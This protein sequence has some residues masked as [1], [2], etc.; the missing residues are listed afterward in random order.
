[1]LR[2]PRPG[3]SQNQTSDSSRVVVSTDGPPGQFSALAVRNRINNAFSEKGI[4]EPVIN[5]VTKSLGNNLILSTTQSFDSTFLLQHQDLWKPIVPHKAVQKDQIWYKVVCHGI[6][7]ADFEDNLEMVNS[8]IRTFNKGLSPIGK[9][10]W[11]T[12]KT[13]RANQRAGSVVVSF[14]TLEEA[15][16]AIKHRL[17]IAG[18]SVRVQKYHTINQD[19]QC[20]NCQGFGHL[21]N[22]CKNGARCGLCAENH[23]TSTHSC[24]SCATMAKSCLHLIPK[25]ANCGKNHVASEKDCEV[26]LAIKKGPQRPRVSFSIRPG[27][28]SS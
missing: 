26:S 5:T 1:M 14:A 2:I 25:C 28:E 7:I 3:L 18:I 8:E 17:Y 4:K 27:W 23:A 16:K 15:Q 12:S 22:R 11:L 10:Y 21:T 19:T 13:A 9:P 20:Q 24:N 6:P